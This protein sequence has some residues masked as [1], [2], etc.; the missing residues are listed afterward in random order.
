MWAFQTPQTIQQPHLP[1]PFHKPTAISPKPQ[2]CLALRPST[3]TRSNG[4]SN[5]NNPLI[6]SL[7]KQGNLNQALQVLSQEPNPTQHTYELLIL[8]CTRQNS[9]PQGIDLHRHLIHDGSDQDP[10]LATKLINMYS[11]LDSIDNARKVFDKTRKRTIYVWN[12]LFRALTLA[13]Y[14][15]EVLD[16]YRRMNRIGVPSDRFTYTYVLK[17]CVA[18]EAFV[19]LLLNGREIHGHIL[20]HGFEGHVHI[21]T[22][23]LDMYA[24]FGCV[25]NASRVF[26]QMPVKNVVSWSAMIACYSKNGKPLEALE[27]FR[28][29]MLENQDLLPN[30]VTMVSVLQA[31]A[32]LAALEQG[33]LMHGYILRRGL[34]SILPVVSALVTVYARCG[35][36]ELGHRVFERMEKRDV[37]SWNSLISSYGI[38]GF[39][40]KA[41]QIFKEMIDQGLSPSPISF[42]SVLGACS[43]AGLV[44]EGKVLFESMVRGHKIFPSVEHYACM[45]DLLGRANRLDEAAKII[46]DMRIEPGPKVWGSLLGSCRIHC[47]VELAE[48]ATSRL[49]ELEPTNAGNYVL[50]ADIYAEAKMW[51][52]VKRVKMLLEAR[53]LQKV[54]GRS[55]IE[56]RRKIYSFMSVDE[57]NPQIEQLHA[58]LLKLS[59][60]MKEK[61]YVPDTKVVLYDLDPEEKERIVLG[62]SEKLALA[63]GLIN[64]KKGETIRIT[65]NLRLCEDCHSVTKFISKFANREI[66]VRDVN[67]F[68]LFQDGVCSCGDYW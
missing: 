25:L 60:E 32:A 45:V 51:N 11:E 28:K 14:G 13:G 59:M 23:L 8:S 48:R 58:L 4:D 43:H 6:Q 56:I 30:S 26:D 19:S 17:A 41:I 36:L 9:L 44:E 7:C 5:N 27:L 39:G 16:L 63:F 2:C 12:A 46:D 33:K 21:M 38:H 37:V 61:G 57:F 15:R 34:D 65:K 68:H 1:K 50:L 64:S 22:T 52:E 29:M 10:F 42:V 67:R 54:P 24:R 62:H 20:R 3:T 31:C 18:S 35:N 47:N 49:F 40:R 55:C 53:G 66:L